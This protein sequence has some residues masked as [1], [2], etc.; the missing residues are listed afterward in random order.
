MHAPPA[1]SVNRRI[2][3]GHLSFSGHTAGSLPRGAARNGK[4]IPPDK[5]LGSGS[6]DLPRGFI[7]GMT[8]TVHPAT[9]SSDRRRTSGCSSRWRGYLIGVEDHRDLE[10]IDV[11]MERGSIRVN[12]VAFS[13]ATPQP[14]RAAYW[15]TRWSPTA[16]R[17]CS[18]YS[19]EV[20]SVVPGDRRSASG[21]D[22]IAPVADF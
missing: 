16:G 19:R 22:E 3:S 10:W 18:G 5:I 13:R 12:V 4:D 8:R 2:G 21:K 1:H 14:C 15:S 7:L 20:P 11:D 9:A 17:R 6:A